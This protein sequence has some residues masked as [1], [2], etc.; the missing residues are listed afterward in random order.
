MFGRK[1]QA[2]R[3]ITPSDFGKRGAQLN[4]LL[5]PGRLE[6]L[7]E[8][9]EQER[10]IVDKRKLESFAWRPYRRIILI[11]QFRDL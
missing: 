7:G 4:V 10:A 5:K 2:F 8:L 6:A 1:T 3:I 9:E 11:V